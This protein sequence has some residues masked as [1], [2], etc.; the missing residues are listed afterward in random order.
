MLDLYELKE[1]WLE[2]FY[3][4]RPST[5]FNRNQSGSFWSETFGQK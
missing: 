1:N 3:S 5:K 4:K 2:R